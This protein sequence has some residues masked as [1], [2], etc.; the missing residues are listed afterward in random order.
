MSFI[1][2]TPTAG[3]TD[4]SLPSRDALVT[5]THHIPA[6]AEVQPDGTVLFRIWAPEADFITLSIAGSDLE[7]P[8]AARPGGW[9]ELVTSE[10]QAGTRYRY[11]LPDGTRV[12][13]PA[14]RFQPEDVR[15]P[16]EVID[17]ASYRWK[18]SSWNGRPWVEAVI[19]ELHI[20]AFTQEGIFLAAIEKLDY[21][22][23]L[24]VTAIEI[25]PVGDFPGRRNWGYDGVLLYAPDSSYGRPEHMKALVEAAHL[26]GL[27][28]ILDVVYNHFGPDGN[29]LSLYAPKIFTDRH[30][31][32]WGDAVNFDSHGSEVVREFIIH[33]ALYW[34]EEF[35]LDGLRLD[36]VHTIKDD[37]PRHVLDELA[38]RV[39]AAS[40]RPVHLI[41]ENERNQASRLIRN[42]RGE[43][44]EF[45]AQWN[46]DIHHVLHTAA[47]LESDGYYRDYKDDTKKLGRA[48]AEGFAFQGEVMSTLKSARGEPSAH[49]P[50]D[51]FVAFIQNHDQVGN[52]AFGERLGSIAPV[53]AVRAVAAVYLLLPQT[54]MLFMGEEWGS[55]QPFLFFCDFDGELGELVRKGRREEFSSFPE[56]RDPEIRETIPDPQSEATFRASKLDWSQVQKGAH[57]EW[58]EWYR[59]ILEVRKTLVIPHVRAMGGYAGTYKVI[60][61]NAV[62]V[63]FSNT[64]GTQK[65]VLTANLSK[66]STDGFP[67]PGGNSI[68][69]EGPSQV[70]TTMG[71]WSIRWAFQTS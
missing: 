59:R 63:R 10:A 60:G 62:I 27:M 5:R 14:S 51:A 17:P 8:L 18:D 44:V 30:K 32:P 28:V 39:R 67:P 36:A 68:W 19:Y 50:S 66:T 48:L 65:L 64:D 55:L 58:L 42:Q 35:N 2:R 22:V 1:P 61:P 40:T 29:F 56:F 21:L 31:T 9:H 4:S 3:R 53:E 20:G 69:Q 11:I 38:Q 26:R 45:T 71:P 43:P 16:S 6:G 25:M 54:P 41:L 23:D 47:T 15:G 33:N 46:D 52:R 70:A 24:G 34:I 57:G 49:L 13:D 37:G 12:P 7:I